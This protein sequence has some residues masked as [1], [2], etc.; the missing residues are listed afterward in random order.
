MH[1][2]VIKTFF[3]ISLIFV[4]N[5]N[6]SC[7][8]RCDDITFPDQSTSPYILPFP[9]GKSYSL[10]QGYCIAPGHRNRLAY[11]F[12]IPVGAEITNSRPGVVIEIQ[13]DF[14]D[15]DN[16]AGH[17]N[18]VVI[19]HKDGSIAWYAHLKN[20]S[21]CVALGDTVDY[22][23]LIGLCGTSGRSGNV[24]HLHFE[25]FKKYKYDYA[26][27]IPISFNNLSGHVDHSGA[28]INSEIYTAL[29]FDNKGERKSNAQKD[30]PA[31][32]LLDKHL[33]L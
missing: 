20:R 3:T 10:Y 27:A 1:R 13:N 11:D 6:V 12:R 26:D 32:H 8:T 18:R 30:N 14:A 15:D 7:N 21:I 4:S 2:I 33:Q 23:E 28:L 16:L 17:N 9:A 29:S 5:L 19:Q 24:P 25:V 22:G 31:N